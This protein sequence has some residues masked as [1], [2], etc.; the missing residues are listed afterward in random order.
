MH[1]GCP[2]R[3][4]G[5]I[6]D[7]VT[8]VALVLPAAEARQRA[9]ALRQGGLAKE[10]ER[11]PRLRGRFVDAREVREL[12][13]TG[14]CA[15]WSR[16]AVAPGGGALLVGDAADFFDPF[17]GQGLYAALRGAEL[18]SASV[19]AAFAAEGGVPSPRRHWRPTARRARRVRRQMGAGA[20]HR[21]RRGVAVA[22]A[23]GRHPAGAAP[24]PGGSCG[25]G[26]RQLVPARA[27]L[28]PPPFSGCSCECVGCRSAAVSPFAR[29]LRDR[30]QRGYACARRPAAGHDREF[31]RLGVAR[32][33]VVACGGGPGERDA[34]DTRGVTAFV[35]NILAADQEALSRAFAAVDTNRFDG[36]GYRE[37][38]TACRC[39]T[40]RW[41]TS[42]VPAGASRAGT[43]RCSLGWSRA[44]P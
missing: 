18:A 40:A 1:I 29:S 39:S 14:P 13:V 22:R 44:G 5:P 34:P 19:I 43:I 27:V 28:A 6:G 4:L 37:V 3:G 36:V 7:G 9:A 10:L 41:P 17:T 24:R 20:A 31:H 8:T 21:I 38:A 42:S 11:F 33:A 25:R 23:P 30:R 26:D 32:P 12:L 2:V 16:R 35:V 15:Q